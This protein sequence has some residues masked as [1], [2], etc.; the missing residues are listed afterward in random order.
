MPFE[1]RRLVTE[2]EMNLFIA[3]EKVKRSVNQSNING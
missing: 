1:V 3:F 2:T